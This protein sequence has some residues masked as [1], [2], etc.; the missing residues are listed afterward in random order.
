VRPENTLAAFRYALTNEDVSTLEL[1]TG[2]T[3]DGRVVVLHDRRVNGSHCVDTRPARRGDPEFPYVGELVR[4]LTLRQLRTLDCGVRTLDEFPRQRAVPGERIPT[5]DE[6]LRLVRAS[7]RGDVRLNVETKISPTAPEESAPYREFTR[8]V[9]RRLQAWGMV[10]RATLQSF[11]WRTIR[12]ARRLHR[13]LQTAA[14]VW[15]DGPA[16]C[17]TLADECSLRAV[18]DDSSVTSPWTAGVDW[19]ELRDLGAMARAIGAS[20]VWANR[21]VH[22]PDQP[23]V[24]DADPYRRQDAR[25]SHGPEVPEIQAQGVRVVPC[26]IDD[27]A[28]MERAI[29]LGVVG[30]ITDDPDLLVLVARRNGLR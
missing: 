18:Y 21:Q 4:E 29:D 22:D 27:E 19:W 23:V 17:A 25:S 9:V 6:L 7:G 28:I 30:V 13:R 8:R 3:R 20:T 2:I 10:R 12:E 14:L 16:E 11:D 1:D 24:E 26:T 5:L 15:Q